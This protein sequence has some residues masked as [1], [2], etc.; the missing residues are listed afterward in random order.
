MIVRG[1]GDERGQRESLLEESD[2]DRMMLA[3]VVDQDLLL[4]RG[5]RKK[6]SDNIRLCNL[7][8]SDRMA[9]QFARTED[10]K[11]RA[12]IDSGEPSNKSAFW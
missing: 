1:T 5:K 6:Q 7:L 11:T 10:Q 9:D 2:N 3:A 4:P 12:Q 8:F